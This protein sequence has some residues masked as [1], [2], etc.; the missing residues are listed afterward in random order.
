MAAKSRVETAGRE[1]G[2]GTS[3]RARVQGTKNNVS[4][5][6]WGRK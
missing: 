2:A 6:G 5:R 1:T 3:M 4:D